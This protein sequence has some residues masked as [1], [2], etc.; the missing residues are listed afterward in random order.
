MSLIILGHLSQ[1]KDLLVKRTFHLLE[2]AISISVQQLPRPRDAS[3]L[4]VLDK[5]IMDPYVEVTLYV[6][7]WLVVVGS[8]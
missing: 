5:G 7:D 1:K 2:V 4:E 6:P 3:D 8:V